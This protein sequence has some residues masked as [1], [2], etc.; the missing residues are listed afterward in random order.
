MPSYAPLTS[1]DPRQLGNLQIIGKLGEGGQGVVYLAK[2]PSDAYV[3]VKW[4]QSDQSDDHVSVGRFLREAEVAQRVAPFCTAAVLGTGVQDDRPYIV[5]EFVEG[6]SLQQVVRDEGPRTGAALDRLAIG[7]A[8]ALAAIHQA[9]I[10][11]RDFKPANVIIG[12]DGPRVIDFGIAR[13]LNATT[14][15]SNTPIGTP[16]YMS[17]EQFTGEAIGP[18]S[19][20]FSWAGTMVYASC[21]RAPFGS[22]A[23]HPLISRVLNGPPDVGA[24]EG[25]LR[26]VVLE[27]FSK[28]PGRR[29]TAQQVIMRLLGHSVP[30]A[31][32]LEQGAMEASPSSRPHTGGIQLDDRRDMGGT[33]RGTGPIVAGVAA[34]AALLIVLVVAAVTVVLDKVST[35]V[36]STTAAGSTTTAPA[37]TTLTPPSS[38][39]A[40]TTK[41]TLPGGAITLH[42][43]PSDP[44]T[45]TAYEVYNRNLDDDVDYARQSLRD[46]TF[47]RHS[48]NWE[49]LVSPDGRYLAGRPQDY[50]SDD[51]DSIL[52]TDRQAG[53]SFRVKTVRKPLISTLR[54]WSKDSSKVLLNIDKK[55][56][57]NKQGED[58]WASLGFAIVDV[59]QAKVSVIEVTDTSVQDSDYGWDAAE[60]GVVIV[61]GK[62]E[63]L[64]FFDAAGKPTRDVAGVGPLAS[65]TLDIFSP[66]GKMFVT[67]CPGGGDGDHCLFDTGTGKRV[68]TFSSDCDKV[69]G[70]YDES[71][72]YCWEQDNGANDEVRVVAFDGKLTRTLLEV[73]EDLDF[74]PYFTVNP[75]GS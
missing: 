23:M 21:G 27:C 4:L 50:T 36:G 22:G 75:T 74:T 52:F 18:A 29:P 60:T 9:G 57:D 69:L 61:Y 53:A 62:D 7:T 64:R 55:I 70:W 6:P 67:D 32:L 28:D 63:G 5:S 44:I 68:R 71:H 14:T 12:A 49:S 54:A 13:A 41:R 10:V 37:E 47:D 26:D 43:H 42:E 15:F 25:P 48:G 24:L 11:H 20:M 51:Y 34:G 8:T 38:I 39:P 16:A 46:D 1:G 73:P 2:N 33:K 58:E 72:L 45:L 40:T 19:D 56:K 65:G 3:A 66:S 17:P 35:A 59:A 31:G 30:T